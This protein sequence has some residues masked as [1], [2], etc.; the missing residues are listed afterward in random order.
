MGI[1]VQSPNVISVKTSPSEISGTVRKGQVAIAYDGTATDS[2]WICNTAGVGA[3][4]KWS[5]LV[6]A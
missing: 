1:H 4:A 2:M 6:M 3:A 5:K